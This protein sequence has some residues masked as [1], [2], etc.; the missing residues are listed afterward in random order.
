MHSA[1]CPPA[2]LASLKSDSTVAALCLEIVLR[3]YPNRKEILA[4]ILTRYLGTVLST[5]GSHNLT[6][7]GTSIFATAGTLY[8]YLIPSVE[9]TNIRMTEETH[10][11]TIEG[12]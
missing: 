1:R 5:E 11:L 10:I 7:V 12:T 8:P 4:E 3:V 6:T 2:R 9:G